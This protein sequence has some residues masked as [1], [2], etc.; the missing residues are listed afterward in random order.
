MICQ[1][2]GNPVLAENGWDVFCEDLEVG[3]H[4][5]HQIAVVGNKAIILTEEE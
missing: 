2:C 3:V 1:K 5:E 4:Y